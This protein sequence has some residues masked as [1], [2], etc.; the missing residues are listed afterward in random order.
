MRTGPPSGYLAA[1]ACLAC[2]IA[3]AAE[4]GTL[5]NT[6]EERQRL[7]RL[8]RGEPTTA[9]AAAN[10]DPTRTPQVTGFVKRSDGRNTV[11]ID[12]VP[13]AVSRRE[14]ARVLDQAGEKPRKPGPSDVRIERNTAKP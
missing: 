6:P 4:L 2:A 7:D 11:W 3:S 13:V 14:A 12:G 9:A 5:F 8:R 1:A 10:R